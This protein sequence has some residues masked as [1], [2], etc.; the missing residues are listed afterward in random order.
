MY[1]ILRCKALL[2][3]DTMSNWGKFYNEEYQ[4]DY[5]YN[6]VTGQSQ[7]EPPEGFLESASSGGKPHESNG[8]EASQPSVEPTCLG[9]EEYYLF[10]PELAFL[11]EMSRMGFMSVPPDEEVHYILSG[12]INSSIKKKIEVTVQVSLIPLFPLTHVSD[13]YRRSILPYRP[14]ARMRNG[15]S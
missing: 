1:C 3:Q 10:N 12:G 11:D 8:T 5:Y 7:W 2:L 13:C 14:L 6:S 4:L 15:R 9:D